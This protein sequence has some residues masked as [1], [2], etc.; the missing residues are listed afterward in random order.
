MHRAREFFLVCAGVL[1]AAIV[2]VGRPGQA[3]AQ[4]VIVPNGDCGW[5]WSRDTGGAAYK[6]SPAFDD[7]PWPSGCTPFEAPWAGCAPSGTLLGNGDLLIRRDLFNNGGPTP[8]QVYV[9]GRSFAA[10][11]INGL[12]GNSWSGGPECYTGVALSQS[13]VLQPGRNAVAVSTHFTDPSLGGNG[14]GGYLDVLITADNPTAVVM[15]SWGQLKV[16]YR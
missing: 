8:A 5:R 9:K 6:S 15:K 2:S 1:L 13:F 16:H 14:Y 7:S 4:G 10:L 11:F 3:E 12:E